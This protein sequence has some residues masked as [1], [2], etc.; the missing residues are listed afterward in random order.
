MQSSMESTP[1][2][3]AGLS[4]ALFGTALLLWTGVR[5]RSHLPVAHGVPAFTAAAVAVVFGVISLLTGGWVLL[6]A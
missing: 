3:F 5:L 1:S 6:A 4:L 2:V